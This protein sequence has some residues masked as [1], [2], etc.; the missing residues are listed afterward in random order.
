MTSIPRISLS[1]TGLYIVTFGVTLRVNPV[2]MTTRVHNHAHCSNNYIAVCGTVLSGGNS[3]RAL[4]QC[5]SI[6]K[7]SMGYVPTHVVSYL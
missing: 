5:Q 4:Q 3:Y 1:K 7:I 2:A 6:N